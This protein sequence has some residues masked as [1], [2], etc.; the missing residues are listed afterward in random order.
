MWLDKYMHG[1][2]NSKMLKFLPFLDNSPIC[3][4]LKNKRVISPID[5]HACIQICL[6]VK[7]FAF[8]RS[9][10]SENRITASYAYI[11]RVENAKINFLSI[12]YVQALSGAMDWA[13]K[14]T[15]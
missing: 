8:D 6:D 15:Y 3:T 10:Q 14:L 12:A 5:P 9:G 13:M 4:D 7:F 11:S 1:N 2:K